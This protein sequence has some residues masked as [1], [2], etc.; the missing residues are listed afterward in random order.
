MNSVEYGLGYQRYTSIPAITRCT[1]EVLLP[2]I[3]LIKL[4][5]YYIERTIPLTI[6]NKY[7]ISAYFLTL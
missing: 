3:T 4:S 7:C 6:S 5:N 2:G 1:T